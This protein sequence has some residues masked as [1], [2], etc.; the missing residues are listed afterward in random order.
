[1]KHKREGK[2]ERDR[3]RERLGLRETF[4]SGGVKE[5]LTLHLDSLPDSGET[6]RETGVE[7]RLGWMCERVLELAPQ[8][9]LNHVELWVCMPRETI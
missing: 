1:M 6:Q 5:C 2:G 9:V 8:R 3:E 7:G 4:I